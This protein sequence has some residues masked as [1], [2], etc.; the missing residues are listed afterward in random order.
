MARKSMR[1]EIVEAAVDQFH[2]KG[3]S[4]A[5]VKDIT[6]AAGVPKGSFYNHF[7]SKEAL[8]V[9]ALE[10][11]GASRRLRELAAVDVAPLARLREH[12]EFLRDEITDYG[13]TRGCLFG[14]FGTEVVD[15]SDGIRAAVDGSLS[16]WMG[17]IGQAITEAQRDGAIRTELDPPTLARFVVNAW[18]GAVIGVRV[19]RSQ[20]SFDAFFDVVFGT[21]LAGPA[22]QD[23][24]PAGV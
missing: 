4:A 11:Y 3:F 24:E 22:H 7:A 10:R 14:N 13:F 9:V 6:D 17:L 12:F 19:G 5:G 23:G 1:E 8:G 21:L 16:A 20:D 2:T 18:E 15:H